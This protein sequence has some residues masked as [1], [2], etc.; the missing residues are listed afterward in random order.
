MFD[1]EHESLD[2]ACDDGE[3]VREEVLDEEQEPLDPACGDRE[4]VG[5]VTHL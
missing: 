5:C 4:T 2:T 3:M 1:E